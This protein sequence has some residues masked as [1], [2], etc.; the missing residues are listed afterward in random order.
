[1]PTPTTTPRAWWLC[2]LK[3]LCV[4]CGTL[5]IV[6]CRLPGLF[7]NC[8]HSPPFALTPA[9][10]NC[11]CLIHTPCQ[12]TI[13]PPFRIRIPV[14]P[15]YFVYVLWYAVLY[16][17]LY[18]FA[19]LYSKKR[20]PRTL[21]S[22]VLAFLLQLCSLPST[23]THTNSTPLSTPTTLQPLHYDFPQPTKR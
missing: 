2:T 10:S 1:M 21:L 7:L 16:C 9:L 8:V 12:N 23:N 18:S 20:L 3:A 22:L 13:T 11:L 5:Y 14:F 19:I 15:H 6:R 17:R 4:C